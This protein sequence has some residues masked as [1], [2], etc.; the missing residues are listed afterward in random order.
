MDDFDALGMPRSLEPQIIDEPNLWTISKRLAF[1]E[2][3]PQNL[4]KSKVLI[5]ANPFDKIFQNLP[6]TKISCR[7]GKF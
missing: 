1:N 5:E 7:D 2:K 4:H 3:K 6:K